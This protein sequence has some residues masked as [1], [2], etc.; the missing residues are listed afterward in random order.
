VNAGVPSRVVRPRFGKLTDGAWP[1][2]VVAEVLADVLGALW[3]V[4]FVVRVLA[5]SERSQIWRRF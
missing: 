4:G 3:S 1:R 5:L 2:A